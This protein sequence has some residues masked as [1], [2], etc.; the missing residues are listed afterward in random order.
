MDARCLTLPPRVEMF[1]PTPDAELSRRLAVRNTASPALYQT[2][3]PPSLQQYSSVVVASRLTTSFLYPA[4]G[5]V[6]L[7]P[8]VLLSLLNA[9]SYSAMLTLLYPLT[10][11]A[12]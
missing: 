2:F 12:S 1:N 4:V 8:V 9:S 7:V 10:K 11:Y 5:F 3:Q 6:S